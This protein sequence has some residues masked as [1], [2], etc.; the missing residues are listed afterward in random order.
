MNRSFESQA[1]LDRDW[2]VLISRP[3][4]V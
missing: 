4:E 1:A 2:R 3:I